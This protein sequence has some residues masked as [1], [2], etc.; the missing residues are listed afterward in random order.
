MGGTIPGRCLEALPCRTVTQHPAA[1]P[2]MSRLWV[3][4]FSHSGGAL[5]YPALTSHYKAKWG[6]GSCLPRH[7]GWG[8]FRALQLPLRLPGLRVTSILKVGDRGHGRKAGGVWVPG[9]LCQLSSCMKGLHLS[10]SCWPHPHQSA[11]C[12]KPGHPDLSRNSSAQGDQEHKRRTL[13]KLGEQTN[14]RGTNELAWEV[15]SG[16]TCVTVWHVRGRS[17]CTR[18]CWTP[19]EALRPYRKPRPREPKRGL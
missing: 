17:P 11:L 6:L 3:L 19:C 16:R 14:I 5:P 4:D 9:C 18:P 15:P 1:L 2:R 8:I 13:L 7:V 10:I 12:A